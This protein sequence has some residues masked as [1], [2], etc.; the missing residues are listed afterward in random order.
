MTRDRACG[1]STSIG[2]PVAAQEAVRVEKRHRAELHVLE[3]RLFHPAPTLLHGMVPSLLGDAELDE[4]KEDR[5]PS[6]HAVVTQVLGLDYQRTTG[7]DR[8]VESPD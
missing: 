6:S 2:E 8:V 1:S 5:P 4:I 3:S 7:G